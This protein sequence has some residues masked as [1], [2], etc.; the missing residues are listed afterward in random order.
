M[1]LPGDEGHCC[2]VASH[3][4]GT[5]RVRDDLPGMLHINT[6]E[7]LQLARAIVPRWVEHRGC[8]IREERFDE[9]RFDEW[10]DST[11]GSRQATEQ[12]LNHLHL[13]DLLVN[14][15]EKDFGELWELGEL[16]VVGWRASLHN[17]FPGREFEV[18]LSDDYGPTVTAATAGVAAP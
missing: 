3:G 10:W 6:E 8:V 1:G 18:T 17:A 12:V 13:W 5:L 15:D 7:A 4:S 9:S 16:M 14:T 11:D 2:G